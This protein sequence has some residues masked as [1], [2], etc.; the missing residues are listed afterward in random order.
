M[1]VLETLTI[2][3]GS[4]IVNTVIRL[5]LRDNE[6]AKD[7]ALEMSGMLTGGISGLL[8]RRRVERQF[9]AATEEIGRR[10]NQFVE[11]E[12]RGL[13]SNEIEAA[14][15]EVSDQ[16]KGAQLSLLA[17]AQLDLSASLIE[18]RVRE[19]SLVALDRVGLSG[20]GV[21]L[22]GRMLTEACNYIVEIAGT[23]PQFGT[24]A[25]AESLRRETEIIELVRTVLRQL[26]QAAGA[27]NP[28]DRDAKFE[29]QYR[30]DIARR[31]DKLEL[32]GVDVSPISRRYSLSVAYIS[33]TI[34][35]ADETEED[36]G[37][38]GRPKRVT[39][40]LGGTSRMFIRGE[41]GSGKTT[42]LSWLAV[43]SARGS[44]EGGLQPWSDRI[45]IYIRLRSHSGGEFPPPERFLNDAT[46]DTAGEMPEG[47]SHRL[48][49]AG[50]GLVLVD[51]VDEIPIEDRDDARRWLSDL[52]E[53]FPSNIYV[54]TSRPAAADQAW[55]SDSGFDH[56]DLDAM[57]LEDTQEL[58][59]RWHA[60]IGEGVNNQDASDDISASEQ[61]MLKSVSS[62]P[63]IRSLATSPLLCAMLCAL[64][65]DRRSE[66]PEDRMELYRIALDMLLERRDRERK[67]AA[68]LQLTRSV[69]AREKRLL[70]QDFALW[71]MLNNYTDAP[72]QDAVDCFDRRTEAL[73]RVHENGELLYRYF[74]E[75]SGVLREPIA[76]RVN[77]VHRTFQEYLAAKEAVDRGHLG[78]LVSRAHLDQWREVVILSAGHAAPNISNRLITRLIERGYAEEENRHKL[79]LL[80]VACLET[81]TD[82]SEDVRE[83]INA[84]LGELLPPRSIGEA[85]A[86]SSAGELA[87]D[88]LRR[89]ARANAAVATACVRALTLIGGESALRA[90][91]DFGPDNRV[92]VARE[93]IRGW[94]SFDARDYAQ[95]VLRESILD[96]GEVEISSVSKIALLPV[97][98]RLAGAS[99]TLT[100]LKDDL[101]NSPGMQYVR[102]FSAWSMLT[103]SLDLR[104]APKLQ[105]LTIYR[106]P[107]L[108]EIRGLR[109]L[110]NLRNVAVNGTALANNFIADLAYAETL[111]HLTIESSSHI[112]SLSALGDRRGISI[113]ADLR[114]RKSVE[115]NTSFLLNNAIS[116]LAPLPS[117]VSPKQIEQLN[118]L[119]S[120]EGQGFR[121]YP[122]YYY[123][124]E[125]HSHS[126]VFEVRPFAL[127]PETK[128]LE[129][130]QVLAAK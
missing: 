12:F 55:L 124:D 116:W 11:A 58:I 8:D 2:G 119:L 19:S 47:W 128:F 7:T 98:E 41:A 10:L 27:I 29:I 102:K 39:E 53:A 64:S 50:R 94:D 121:V 74:V 23:L 48:L 61:N 84:C 1:P 5:W 120:D 89:F 95:I 112:T 9:D 63:N 36:T 4:T 30:R 110:Q 104:G 17:V 59:R 34:R 126:R 72:E 32:F 75:R 81:A 68:D 109:A 106:A 22:A 43:Q 91:G 45:P 65:L 92:T 127:V 115:G 67:I 73:Q 117:G 24:V 14:S 86:I 26:P 97:L 85:R 56:C 20:A 46:P 44:L 69:P 62:L 42:L 78:L 80:A 21:Q 79:H 6:V 54:V 52:V 49:R 99:V 87:V 77:F 125:E 101:E 105:T 71:L 113:R 3:L 40:A 130:S 88:S 28:A 118:E 107:V 129:A 103:N 33:L 35:T 37:S 38:G 90:L 25:A 114:L 70:L 66:V 13:E 31:L 18:A 76:G 16:I 83:K 60:A 122:F 51:G 123:L 111:Q 82:L 93:L 100:N 57:S 96:W 15:R 108:K